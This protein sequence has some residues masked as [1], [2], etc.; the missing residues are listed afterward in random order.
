M[1]T[2]H[3]GVDEQ[4]LSDILRDLLDPNGPHGQGDA[5]LRAFLRLIDY[6][7]GY[8][9]GDVVTVSREFATNRIQRTQRRLD[10]LIDIRRDGRSLEGIAIENKPWAFDQEDQIT[11]YLSHL[12]RSYSAGHYRLVYL[13]KDGVSPPLH[14]VS[15][16]QELLQQRSL[17]LMAYAIRTDCP[18]NLPVWLDICLQLCQS[19]KVRWFLRD[20]IQYIQ[21]NFQD[22]PCA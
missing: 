20:L 7:V 14:S 12:E 2:S 6:E 10:L 15:N 4:R 8:R 21:R 19:E 13:T 9:A 1:T 22:E 5:F 17:L 11:D 16:A 18:Y 3:I